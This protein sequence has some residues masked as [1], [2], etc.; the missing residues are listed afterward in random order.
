VEVAVV[1]EKV[2]LE[3]ELVE[4]VVVVQ[5]ATPELMEQIIS[6]EVAVVQL[7]IVV[8]EVVTVVMV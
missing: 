3:V 1:V 2:R 6:E 4:L 7:I 5:G 8:E